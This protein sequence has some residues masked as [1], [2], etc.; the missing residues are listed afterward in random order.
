MKEKPL[1]NNL[2]I[3]MIIIMT[4]L[5]MIGAAFVLVTN[6][7]EEVT[8]PAGLMDGSLPERGVLAGAPMIY[9][10]AYEECPP[11]DR[12]LLDT[13]LKIIDSDGGVTYHWLYECKNTSWNRTPTTPDCEHNV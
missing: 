1:Q 7:Q 9:I 4:T 3:I 6:T 5:V 12:V 2:I 10:P 11:E 8:H 13:P